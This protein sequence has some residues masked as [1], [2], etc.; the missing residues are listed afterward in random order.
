MIKFII[1][2]YYDSGS[3]YDG[4]DRRIINIEPIKMGSTVGFLISY[5]IMD[6]PTKIKRTFKIN[7]LREH[8][9][10]IFT[11]F[12]LKLSNISNIN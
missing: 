7:L 3:H 4:Y 11:D 1:S 6:S 10:L 8:F 5:T 9:T 12:R 2:N